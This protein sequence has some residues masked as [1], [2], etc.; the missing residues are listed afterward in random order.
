[1][2]THLRDR[3]TIWRRVVNFT[4]RPHWT[5]QLTDPQGWFRCACGERVT[6]LG[7]S[8]QHRLSDSSASLCDSINCRRMNPEE[9]RMPGPNKRNVSGGRGI[10]LALRNVDVTI[11]RRGRKS[12]AGLRKRPGTR[13]TETVSRTAVWHRPVC[14]QSDTSVS[15]GKVPRSGLTFRHRASCI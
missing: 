11:A 15:T 8:A 4:L 13:R 9:L 6:D 1:M 5:G 7:P 14:C 3:P 12:E 2:W 10:E